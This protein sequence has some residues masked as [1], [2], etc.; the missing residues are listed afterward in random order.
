MR[1]TVEFSLLNCTILFS[2]RML[3]LYKIQWFFFY[4]TLY[5]SECQGQGEPCPSSLSHQ[6]YYT[7]PALPPFFVFRD[8]SSNVL[9]TNQQSKFHF[10]IS[11][12][13][14]I[15]FQE[16]QLGHYQPDSFP[17]SLCHLQDDKLKTYVSPCILS[18]LYFLFF[19]HPDLLLSFTVSLLGF[20]IPPTLL[21]TQIFNR[22]H[23][24]RHDLQKSKFWTSYKGNMGHE[25]PHKAD[26]DYFSYFFVDI[27]ST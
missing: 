6:Q 24:C 14:T 11:N 20:S 13:E 17:L 12:F 18:L 26:F 27:I 25:V 15:V 9:P 19:L 1:I 2:N 4:I 16:S 8:W 21:L 23:S 3:F 7:L 10:K 22:F 5:T